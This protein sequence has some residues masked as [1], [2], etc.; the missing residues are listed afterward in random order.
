MGRL[1]KN[2]VI[3]CFLL[4]LY[5]VYA[6]SC[7]GKA[8]ALSTGTFLGDPT[9]DDGGTRTDGSDQ[10][11]LYTVTKIVEATPEITEWLNSD[12]P[13]TG[14]RRALGDPTINSQWPFKYEFTYPPNNY[15]IAD[16]RILLATRRDSSDTEGIFVDGVLT[17]YPPTGSPSPSSPKILYRNYTCALGACTGGAIPNGTPNLF[18]M[19]FALTH[20]KINLPNTFDLALG[21]L[22]KFTPLTI[23]G[24]LS[25]GL[26]RVVSGDDAVI[27]PDS[28][29][30]ETSKPLL[31][32]EGFTISKTP[33]VCAQSPIYKIVNTYIH[34][35]GNSIAAPA[36]TGTVVTP[37][38]SYATNY[39]TF[40]SV[41]FFYDPKLP[42]LASYTN[43]NITVGN[44]PM[45]VKRTNPGPAAIVINGI[46]FDQDG[47]DRTSASAVVES[48]ST[49]A[50]ARTYWNTF[51]TT[52][53]ATNVSTNATLNLLSLFSAEKV[54]ELLLQGKLNIAIAGPMASVYGQGATSGRTY[55]VAVNGPD[56]V[57]KGNYSAEIC[58]IPDN[59]TSPLNGGVVGPTSCT[60]DFAAPLISSI[61]V[62]SITATSAKIQWLTNE[63]SSSQVG[64]GAISPTTL[65]TDNVA[66]VTFHS[67]DIT[68][69]Q[70]YKFY[71][72]NVRSTDGCT[73]SATSATKSFRT[74]R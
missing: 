37:S 29:P 6:T 27:Y 31:L 43:L 72:Y 26:L 35:D 39:T 22:L 66:Q 9:V 33:L 11:Q 5:L 3:K 63:G 34:N 71:Q 30:N 14:P 41:E 7:D 40:R 25:D 36:F 20:Y 58:D 74:L 8:E 23:A 53:P 50:A 2:F 18:Y 55:G 67:V 46:G 21:E 24:V 70:P 56:L 38:A 32:L 61:Q 68:G 45:Q 44:I 17:G 65:T 57:L 12:L 16:A 62:S 19:D 47:F 1:A 10:G 60:M 59:P 69:L 64:Y 48:W 73:N 42:K 54:K 4:S 28:A 49:D 15:A 52:V 13:F 51:V